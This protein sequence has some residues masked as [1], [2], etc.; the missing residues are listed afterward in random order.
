MPAVVLCCVPMPLSTSSRGPGEMKGTCGTAGIQ[1]RMYCHT[2]LLWEVAPMQAVAAAAH[3]FI[4]GL[5]Q[6]VMLGEDLLAG[7]SCLQKQ[8]HLFFFLSL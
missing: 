8:A 3:T 2:Y 7:R 5:G 4:T 1:H 6:A